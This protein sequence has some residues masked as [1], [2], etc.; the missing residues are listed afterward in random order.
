MIL[1]AKYILFQSSIYAF[2]LFLHQV[3]HPAGACPGLLITMKQPGV[4]LLYLDGMQIHYKVTP[5]QHFIR[6]P[7]QL[8]CWYLF[9]CILWLERGTV[10][11]KCFA[12]EHN[13]LTQ[14]HLEFGFF[15]LYL[16]ALTIHSPFLL[17]SF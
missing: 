9:T 1:F 15:D 12:E 4:S 8:T 14:P 7:W 6:L 3:A 17:L 11:A 13:I 5:P 2:S 16:S 10:R